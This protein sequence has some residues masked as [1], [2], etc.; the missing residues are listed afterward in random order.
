MKR[1]AFLKKAGI[2]TA[3]AFVLPYI[4]PSGR[5]FAATGSR[6]VNHVVLV[7]FAG[8]L[9]NIE[10]VKQNQSNLMSTM[11][12]D[13]TPFSTQA[14][15]GDVLPASPLGS[16]RLQEY[17]TLMKE[18]RFK[19]GPTGHFNGHITALTG[20][21]SMA[22][23]NLRTNPDYPTIF[24]YYRKHNDDTLTTGGLNA[25]WISD[26]LGPYPA[27]NYSAY[28]GYGASYGANYIQ[29]GSLLSWE[30]Y[31]A[32]GKPKNF[33]ADEMVL[34]NKIRGFCDANFANQ[35][36]AESV[37]VVNSADEREQLNAFLKEL[38]QGISSPGYNSWGFG[39]GMTNDLVNLYYSEKVIQKF[40][41]ELTVLN[42]QD[43]DI[44]HTDF[45]KYCNGLRKAD[46]G[47]SHLWNT[48]E[49]TPGMAGDTVMIVVPEH[50]RNYSPN[51]VVDSYGRP[52]YDHNSDATSR[53]IFCM[54]VGP[55]NVVYQD[56]VVTQEYGES[57][58]VVPTIADLLGFKDRIPSGLLSGNVL[59]QAIK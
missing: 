4:L 53:E 54:I 38:Y 22:D 55:N 41:P 43:V 45:T 37:G 25:W 46:W 34:V 12:K 9:R 18:F 40:K 51:T 21:Y 50:G 32:I 47:V 6:K 10:T 56:K 19:E 26:S 2:A 58:D 59:S 57:I 23:I 14:G 13:I 24:E 44:C 16:K 11:L 29:P 31:N 52:A 48:I 39:N 17:G 36:A 8:G 49:N 5:L 15:I 7:L 28:P 1:R 20:R 30:G 27:L 42:M 35:Y 3:G 33:T